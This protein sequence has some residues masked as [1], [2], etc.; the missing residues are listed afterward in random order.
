MNTIL[1]EAMLLIA[2]TI[3]AVPLSAQNDDLWVYETKQVIDTLKADSLCAAKNVEYNAKQQEQDFKIYKGR[4]D[5]EIELIDQLMVAER[6]KITIVDKFKLREKLN[7][8]CVGNE[9]VTKKDMKAIQNFKVPKGFTEKVLQPAKDSLLAQI[10]KFVPQPNVNRYYWRKE[11]YPRIVKEMEDYEI[12]TK[13]YTLGG[14]PK[15]IDELPKKS[16]QI[17]KPNPECRDNYFNGQFRP[18]PHDPDNEYRRHKW[19]KAQQSKGWEWV[20]IDSM[21]DKSI[22]YPEKLSWIEHPNHPEY[23]FKWRYDYTGLLN[24]YNE[25][26]QLVRVGNILNGWILN[27]MQ[28][29]VMT[30]ICKRDFLAN[31]YDINNAGENTLN[32]LRSRLG[33]KKTD[34]ALKAEAETAKGLADA[35]AK[36]EAARLEKNQAVTKKEYEKAAKKERDAVN[37]GAV[38]A[39]SAL[40]SALD[41]KADNYIKQLESDH[42]NDMK[43]LYKIERIDNTTFKVYYLNDKFECGC[44]ALMKWYNKE[45]YDAEFEIELLPCE[46]ITIRR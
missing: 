44:I 42:S 4:I 26:G 39:L 10:D 37:A 46:A 17:P 7:E 12:R 24:A 14:K 36:G 11:D 43:Y 23:R 9:N 29:K 19:D 30:A 31:K 41:E 27:D 8:L 40:A 21:E 28:K 16:I 20:N 45:V 1:K 38:Y 35:V 3:A 34:K 13:G 5:A 2:A 33:V 6:E 15:R 25:S 32:A 18:N 22:S